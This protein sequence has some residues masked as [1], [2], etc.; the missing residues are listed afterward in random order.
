MRL[1]EE[2]YAFEQAEGEK[3]NDESGLDE[4]EWLSFRHPEHSKV[5][6]REMAE[7]ILAAFGRQLKALREDAFGLFIA[8]P[9][10]L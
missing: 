9:S 4:I 8:Y 5:M 2:R 6:L 1:E 3:A 7:E 10:R